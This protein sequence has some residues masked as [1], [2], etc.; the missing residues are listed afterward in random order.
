MKNIRY[1]IILLAIVL[2]VWL[3]PA[4]VGL[5]AP[6]QVATPFVQYSIADSSFIRFETGNHQTRYIDMRGQE[7]TKAECDS[8]LPLFSFRQ[9][10]AEGRLPDTIGGIAV[11]PKLIQQNAFY[12]KT[13]PK[14]LS[15]P[16]IGLY[17]PLES[18]SGLVN[19]MLPDDVFR[20]VDN[21]LEFIDC[22]TNQV[23]PARS[24]SYTRELEKYGFVFP[25]RLIWGNASTRKDYDNGF[26]LTDQNDHLYQLRRVKGAPFVR[27]IQTDATGWKQLFTL[28]PA[29]RQLI[30]M[31]V[32]QQN[33]LY[34]VRQNGTTTRV[35]IDEY[36]PAT[37]QITIVGDLQQW[38]IVLY[39]ESD[40]RYY[41]VDARTF[42]RIDAAVIPDPAPTGWSKW[43]K[44]ILPLRLDFTGWQDV[45]IYPRLNQD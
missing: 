42:E 36:N 40:T 32:D 23:L 38:T 12:F 21:G 24:R 34:V 6:I 35:D 25:V 8:L 45:Y 5:L 37:M 3:L 29:N 39:T 31:A 33:Q 9:L 14:Q 44:Y 17:T 30:G 43:R 4:L 18:A 15:K 2:C 22:E 11:N 28:E 7:F 41:A 13:S 27:Q 20:L 1:L 16:Q 26:L 19:L 10:L